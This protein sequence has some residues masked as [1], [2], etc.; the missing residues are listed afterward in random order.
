[1]KI[2]A[3]HNEQFFKQYIDL[4]NGIS[5]KRCSRYVDFFH[6][7]IYSAPMI[8]PLKELI[9][10]NDNIYEITCASTRRAYQLAKIQEPDSEK[11]GDKMVSLGAKQIFTGEVNYQVEYHPEYN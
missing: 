2:V 11:G 7:I 10:F 3:K 5:Q 1:M 8:F 9:E 4:E 6:K